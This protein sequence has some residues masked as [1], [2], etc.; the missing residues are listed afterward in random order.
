MV[1]ERTVIRFET[2]C[3]A[4]AKGVEE[5][6]RTQEDKGAFIMNFCA[7]VILSMLVWLLTVRMERICKR[8]PVEKQN[9]YETMD[10]EQLDQELQKMKDERKTFFSPFHV[11]K[12][13]TNSH[14][15][16]YNRD[17]KT[18]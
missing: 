17:R 9:Y 6:R 8:Y 3:N 2:Q 10:E 7:V 15:T 16:P 1:Q 11:W 12:P 18:R 4:G 5:Q 13:L 14:S